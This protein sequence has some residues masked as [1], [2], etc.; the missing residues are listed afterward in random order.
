MKKIVFCGLVSAVLGLVSVR[1][2]IRP[3]KIF[4]SNMVL[5]QGQ[6]IQIWGWAD[7]GEK[8]TVALDDQSRKTVA[9]NDGFWKVDFPKMRAGSGTHTIRLS[10]KNTIKLTNILV[11]EVWICSGQSN[12][13]FPLNR[14]KSGKKAIANATIPTI[15]L[16]KI[17]EHLEQF[18]ALDLPNSTN[19]L[20]KVCSPESVKG[21]SAVAY[22]FGK[23]IHDEFNVP[24]GLIQSTWGG[25]KAESWTSGRSIKD[26]P[27]F[28]TRYEELIQL[29]LAEM[30]KTRAETIRSALGGTIPE[31]EDPKVL[32]QAVYAQKSF[33]DSAW[34]TLQPTAWE[35]QGI[36]RLDGVAWFRKTVQL[37]AK[38]AKELT[39]LKFKPIGFYCSQIVWVNGTE[40]GQSRS[41]NKL[42][43]YEL[44]AG[45]LHEGQNLVVVRVNN[46]KGNGGL[47]GKSSNGIL[48]SGKK[49]GD[50]VLKGDWKV[51][52][53][54]VYLENL[55]L[56]SN[57]YPTTLFNGMIHPLIA[58]PM[59]GVIWYQGES[60][61]GNPRQY[62]RT[63][64]QLV[65]DW[66]KNWN[67]EFPFLFVCL[68]NFHKLAASPKEV[69]GWAGIRDAQIKTLALPKTGMA[70][71]LDV[72]DANNVHP[73]VKKPV[74]ERLALAALKI[75]YGKEVVYS[76]PVFKS[77]KVK[78]GK[79]KVCYSHVGGGLKACN[80]ADF[81]HGFVIADTDGKFHWAKAK[82]VGKDCVE[83]WSEGVSHPTLIRYAW[84]SNPGEVNLC[85]KEGLLAVPFQQ[86]L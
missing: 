59:R 25:T 79:V 8:V 66:R 57:E 5:Q 26:D 63:F 13:D 71:A 46:K 48:F 33:D 44:P 18:P 80:G 58:L 2:D 9:R 73:T 1:G 30:Y 34:K 72:G 4:S 85:N 29:D 65:Q 77:A 21:F 78:N 45:C 32:K 36:A 51:K 24:V 22:F 41:G 56:S 81:L 39:T 42:R 16:L 75:A 83:V 3:A 14:A 62:K 38:Q 53:T 54:A 60:N 20:W 70:M 69:G 50:V 43:S 47:V 68:P 28:K 19:N 17:N 82:I 61:A 74:G 23:K 10:G 6:P 7:S 52:F 67:R 49:I 64:P 31:K 15:R 40:V 76:G 11:G 86:S 84:S 55:R 12:M 27:D 35:K 37:T